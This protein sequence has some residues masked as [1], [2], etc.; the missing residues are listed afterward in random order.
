ME[1]ALVTG[2]PIIIGIAG[3]SSSGKT[4][5]S[6]A[7]ADKI[8]KSQSMQQT[9]KQITKQTVTIVSQDWFYKTAANGEHHNWDDPQAMDLDQMLKVIDAASRGVGVYAPVH[10]Y[11]TYT[12]ILDQV[13]VPPSNVIIF[14][15]IFAFHYPEIQKYFDIK[16]FI[17]CDLDIA[18][19][20]RMLRDITIR[21]FNAELV[22]TRY[23]EFAKPGFE[24][25]VLPTRKAADIIICNS[26]N[27]LPSMHR[28]VDLV[29][30]Y[31][32]Q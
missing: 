12:Q 25:W 9:T 31:V 18:L 20:W 26:D 21:G 14:E 29:V 19:S 15:G 27:V 3:G 4:S 1:A 24:K 8:E 10:N 7:I 2:K 13:F 28:G 5:F 22:V 6:R 32:K 16:V 11:A 30:G 23:R 17:D